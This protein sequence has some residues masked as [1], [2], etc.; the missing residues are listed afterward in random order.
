MIFNSV[1]SDYLSAFL[2]FP[3]ISYTSFGC[4]NTYCWLPLNYHFSI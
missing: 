2:L 1:N 4:P 3:T